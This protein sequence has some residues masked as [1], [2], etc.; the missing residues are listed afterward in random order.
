MLKAVPG[1]EAYN[2]LSQHYNIAVSAAFVA[3][4]FTVI[5]CTSI[6]N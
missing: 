5:L 6:S 1:G 3:V 2:H 4:T